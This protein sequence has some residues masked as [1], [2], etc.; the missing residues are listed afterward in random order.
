MLNK[1]DWLRHLDG[2]LFPWELERV[3]STRSRFLVGNTRDSLSLWKR[4]GYIPVSHQSLL[5]AE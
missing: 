2:D 5:I 4:G 3:A 1:A